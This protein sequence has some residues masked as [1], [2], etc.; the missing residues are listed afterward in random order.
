M[1]HYVH[2]RTKLG[3]F[4][5]IF[6]NLI[7]T[8][9]DYPVILY[10][11]K[12]WFQMLFRSHGGTHTWPLFFNVL[13]LVVYTAGLCYLE[14][15]VLDQPFYVKTTVHSM[16]GV[17]LGLILVFRTNT[18]YDRWWEG[19]KQLGALVNNSRNFALKLDAML[20]Q[21]DHE[22]REFMGHLIASY[23]FALKEHLRKGV[24]LNQLV[25]KELY[26][27][28]LEGYKHIPN[29]IAG[30]MIKRIDRLYKQKKLT[31]SQY[32]TLFT[33]LDS[34][35]DI[36]GACERIKKTPIPYSYSAYIKKFIFIYAL[37]LPL[38]FIEE[39]RWYAIPA[40]GFIFYALVSI[41][42]IAEEIEDPFGTDA[43]DLPTNTIADNIRRNV[44]EI[45]KISS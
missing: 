20:P 35:T 32:R 25:G 27:D 9:P 38:G 2:I 21:E 34:F 15:H 37:T 24:N 19:R 42:L 23:P 3:V 28:E 29:R 1:I 18:A 10:N 8:K 43:N 40:V 31:G 26:E 6:R 44:Y 17:V 12:S 4:P 33:Q 14:L 5:V 30:L 22:S 16:L 39:F 7:L 11:P 41:E 13:V 45:L 36:I